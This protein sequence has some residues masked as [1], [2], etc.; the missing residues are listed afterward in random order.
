M[1][2]L[3]ELRKGVR[4]WWRTDTTGAVVLTVRYGAKQ[5]EFEKGKTAIPV[6]KK[7]T[8]IPTIDTVIAPVEPGE[9]GAVLT[10][11]SRTAVMTK[12]KR[13]A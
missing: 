2:Q 4:G 6:G 7:E 9:L 3:C 13:V 11:M 1:K 10:T 12:G 5:I 8:L